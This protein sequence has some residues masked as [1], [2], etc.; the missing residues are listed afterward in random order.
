MMYELKKF[1]KMVVSK[2]IFK[3][4]I[5]FKHKG[6]MLN[7]YLKFKCSTNVK[8]YIRHYYYPVF[9]CKNN[10]FYTVYTLDIVKMAYENYNLFLI[11]YDLLKYDKNENNIAQ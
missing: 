6:E 11:V 7:D 10:G 8:D 9:Y 2:A 5:V 3:K 1:E 4:G